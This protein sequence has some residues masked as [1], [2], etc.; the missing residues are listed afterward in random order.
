MLEVLAARR[1][2]FPWISGHRGTGAY[3]PENTMAAF[4]KGWE[5][6]ADLL[7]LDVQR[8]R[9]GQVVIIHDSTLERTTDGH[10]RVSEHTLAELQALD[11]GA[12]FQPAFAGEHIPT[13][14]E[15]VAWAKGR[16]RLNIEIKGTPE[17][18]GDLP[19]QVVDTCRAHGIVG[20]TLIISFDHVAIRRVK[21]REPGL[22]AAICFG[23]RLADPVGAARAALANVLNT[24]SGLITP[25]FC[26]M[27]HQAG[28]GVQCY[29][30]DPERARALARIGV[31]FMDADRPDVVRAAVRG[32]V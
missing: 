14:E 30:D 4:R 27:A 19:E 21:E 10:G 3:A 24:G 5:V 20:E 18:L 28:L 23:I 25:E 7:E 8:S 13:L 6:G 15:L 1:D 9:D 32:G 12:W 29:M 11:A 16:V 22:A 17:T 26:A 31:D 2:G